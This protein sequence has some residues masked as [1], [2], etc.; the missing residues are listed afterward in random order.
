[1]CFISKLSVKTEF[2]IFYLFV[3]LDSIL[4]FLLFLKRVFIVCFYSYFSVPISIV[5][6]VKSIKRK[7]YIIFQMPFY[8]INRLLFLELKI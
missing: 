7:G 4:Q 2:I 8:N 1:M 5:Q 6:R 3:L